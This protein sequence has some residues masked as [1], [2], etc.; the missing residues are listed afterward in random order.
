MRLL[1]KI[2]HFISGPI[3]TRIWWS[4]RKKWKNTKKICPHRFTPRSP[5]AEREY[6][7]FWKG[8]KFKPSLENYRYIAN[9]SDVDDK[10]TVSENLFY[11]VLERCLNN[12][13]YSTIYENKMLYDKFFKKGIF[14][15]TVLRF[16][17]KHFYS[18]DYEMLSIAEAEKIVA[19]V[20]GDMIGKTVLYHC[21][22]HGVSCYRNKDGRFIKNDGS[23]LNLQNFCEQQNAAYIFQEVLQQ[24]EFTKQF[25]PT[26]LNT[27]R[28]ITL[29]LPGDEGRIV[30]LKT[31]LKVGSPNNYVDN[32]ESGGVCVGVFPD[33]RLNAY[34]TSERG[35]KFFASPGTGI[36]FEGLYVKD[37]K[38]IHELAIHLASQIQELRILS[39][40][41]ALDEKNEPRCIEI[42]SASQSPS[43]YFTYG[44]S[45][46]GE[47]ATL[48]R[49]YC[50]K[51]Q[52]DVD[53]FNYLR[54]IS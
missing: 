16:I 23:I 19:G 37:I 28:T 26:C 17:P 21:Q 2:N 12:I 15:T 22:G 46:F 31:L 51:H 24:C 11:P 33:G 10:T 6:L 27:F 54:T 41:I 1:T 44:E 7:E 4:Y 32:V 30:V 29:R 25:N 50:L 34:A 39:M 52:Y 42:N 8:F 5:Q 36:R 18:A 3:K 53:E 20:K 43:N 47:H 35:E 45:L 9:M 14:P 40:D 49:D 38:R 13:N 48:V